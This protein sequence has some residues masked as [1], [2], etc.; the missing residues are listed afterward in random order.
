MEGGTAPTRKVMVVVDPTRESAA[1]LQWALY[2]A[3]LERDELILLHLENPTSWRSRSTFS[4]FKRYSQPPTSAASSTSSSEGGGGG[5]DLDFLEQM[6]RACEVAQPKVRV[7]IERVDMEGKD[8]AAIIL[9]QSMVLSVDLLIIGQR[10]SLSA[11]ILGSRRN[12]GSAKGS[13]TLDTA[14]YLIEHS[15]CT[16]IAVQKKGQNAGFL[17]NSKTHKNFWM[18]A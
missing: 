14:E 11:A 12:G 17:L 9:A 6:K 13:R 16:C 2:H 4:F 18:L 3:V 1:A 10:R 8:K 5:G 7:H 15:K